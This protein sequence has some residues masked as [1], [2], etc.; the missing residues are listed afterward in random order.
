MV[1]D[2]GASGHV[3]L[4]RFHNSASPSLH[5]VLAGAFP[6][7]DGTMKNS[8]SQ[9]LVSPHFGSRDDTPSCA[10]FRSAL[11]DAGSAAWGVGFG[12]PGPIC[13]GETLG[14]SGS[15]GP[16]LCLRP[17]LRPR[18][19]RKHLACWSGVPTRPPPARRRR[20]PR[21]LAFRGSIPGPWHSRSTLRPTDYPDRTLDSLPGVG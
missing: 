7:F 19:D 12:R 11:P 21:L 5:R 18:Q 17:G 16:L 20:L 9:T 6:G 14:L 4:Q 1:S 3:S 13:D 8:D 10:C 15:W 2:F